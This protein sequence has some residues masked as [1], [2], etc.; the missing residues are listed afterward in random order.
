MNIEKN[1]RVVF[2]IT[3]ENMEYVKTISKKVGLSRSGF[4]NS[5]IYLQ[6]DE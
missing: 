5:L 2:Y 6:K 3:P 4:V 1:K